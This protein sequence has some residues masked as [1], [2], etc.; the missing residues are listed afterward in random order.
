MFLSHAGLG[1]AWR[2]VEFGYPVACAQCWG[3]ILCFLFTRPDP[4]AWAP[5]P[6]EICTGRTGHEQVCKTKFKCS[7]V[8]PTAL[9]IQKLL[10]VNW[11]QSISVWLCHACI[12]RTCV[13]FVFFRDD[14]LQSL[15]IIQHCLLGAGSLMPALKGETIPKLWAHAFT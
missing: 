15:T 6:S 13:D 12:Y 3:N 14:V 2:P 11:F 7:P 5:A 9:Q 10:D 1:S 4:P 8:P